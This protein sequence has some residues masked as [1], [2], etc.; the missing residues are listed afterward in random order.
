MSSLGGSWYVYKPASLLI[1]AG[2]QQQV[3]YREW[4]HGRVRIAEDIASQHYYSGVDCLLWESVIGGPDIVYAGCR[5]RVPIV[6]VVTEDLEHWSMEFRGLVRVEDDRVSADGVPIRPT[7]IFTP[8]AIAAAAAQQPEFTP[9]A[10]AALVDLE[11]IESS[12]PVDVHAIDIIGRTALHNAAAWYER[13]DPLPLV[14]ALIEHGADVN[15]VDKYGWT[16]LMI[17]AGLTHA[18]VVRRLI[19][20]GADVLARNENGET[21]LMKAAGAL[22]NQLEMVTLLLQRGANKY[23]RDK[24]G[25]TAFDAIR[26]NTDPQLKVLLATE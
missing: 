9:G 16:A 10:E 3:L 22:D 6:V 2:H 13:E 18:D 4:K 25:H 8:A 5:D 12:V 24:Y 19:E 14:N 20:A 7:L 11:P 1:E 17:A 15:A 21:A 26:S 23:V